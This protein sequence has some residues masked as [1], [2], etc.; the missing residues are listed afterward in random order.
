MWLRSGRVMLAASNHHLTSASVGQSFPLRRS[1]ANLFSGWFQEG[2]EM[3]WKSVKASGR[4]GQAF[5]KSAQTPV[6]KKSRADSAAVS[7]A[8]AGG[9]LESVLSRSG[10]RA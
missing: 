8:K 9:G 3:D 7:P 5:P 1:H 4:L 10:F 6:V 2:S